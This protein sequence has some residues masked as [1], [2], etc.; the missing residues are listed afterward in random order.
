[1]LL[2]D[3]PAALAGGAGA[4]QAASQSKDVT[5]TAAAFTHTS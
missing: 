2:G 3:G 4:R 5:N 1:M